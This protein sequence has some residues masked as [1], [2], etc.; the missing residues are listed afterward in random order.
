MQGIFVQNIIDDRGM[1]F[2]SRGDGITRSDLDIFQAGSGSSNQDNFIAQ[3][4]LGNQVFSVM[5]DIRYR[6]VGKRPTGSHE[7][8]LRFAFGVGKE[9]QG[10]VSVE[11]TIFYA[12]FAHAE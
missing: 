6:I 7:I 4:S 3:T 1:N 12:K 9:F 11:Q 2:H 10:K 8:D 5:N